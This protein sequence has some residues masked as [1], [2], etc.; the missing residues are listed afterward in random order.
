M[1][2]ADSHEFLELYRG[3]K[4]LRMGIEMCGL[5]PD[6]RFVSFAPDSPS[7]NDARRFGIRRTEDGPL[8]SL[9]EGF[10][11]ELLPSVGF[12][13]ARK[14]SGGIVSYMPSYLR[15]LADV[16]PDVI[17]E[18]PFSWLTPRS[19]QTDRFA[20]RT[21]TPSILY[22]P[23][24][25]IAVSRKQKMLVPFERP[26]VNRASR[27][28]T[29]NEVGRRRFVDKYGYPSERIH[30]IPKPVDVPALRFAGDTSELRRRLSK[31][32]PDSLIVGYFGRL[33][34]YKG[35]SVLLDAA[36]RA[37]SDPELADVSFAFLGGALSS[38]ECTES[39]EGPNSIVTG[40]LQHDEVSAYMAA[41]DVLVFPDVTRPGGFPTA[42]AEGMAAGR[43][44]IVGIGQRTDL[45]PLA[46]D[47]TALL[48]EPSDAESILSAI[49]RLVREKGLMFRLAAAV[50][51][52]AQRNMDYPVVARAYL[53][54]A[55]E[56]LVGS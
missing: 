7:P 41:C 20:R 12:R 9:P 31:G 55:E 33:A 26:V 45:M 5:R 35:S 42:V 3:D 21:G 52:Y 13:F 37:A 50:S 49:R 43:T 39:Y 48:A 24:D 2:I 36:R 53:S 40:M 46:H 47:Q 27:I 8:P 11:L 28:I 19:Y 1:I 54:L 17:F 14:E 44:L 22:D 32:R 4:D 18:N 25:E 56:V 16:R 34:H 6:L 51:D 15:R 23:G 30:V 10:T 29:Y 38:L